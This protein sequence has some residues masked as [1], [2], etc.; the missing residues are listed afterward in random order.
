MKGIKPKAGRVNE[1]GLWYDSRQRRWVG[2][3][4]R[5]T[6]ILVLLV[7]LALGA[8]T[9]QAQENSKFWVMPQAGCRATGSFA[10]GG[11][12][13]PFTS[14]NLEAGF[15]YGLTLGYRFHEGV[16]VEATWSRSHS[17]MVGVF[18]ADADLAN[19]KLFDVNEDQF[20]ADLLVSAGYVIGKVQ[21]YFLIGLGLTSVNPSGA[22]SGA[23]RM[24]WN[25]G[26]GLEGT[27]SQRIGLRGQVKLIPTHTINMGAILTEWNGGF[28]ATSLRNTMTQWEFTLGLVFHL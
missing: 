3:M 2:K 10:I 12:T 20:Q 9:A 18:P 16:A 19:E 28:P 6:T 17:G 7:L 11:E 21:P 1:D 26:I 5:Q 27:V 15:A 4:I 22:I 24:A 25:I 8:T 23:T 13:V 14:L